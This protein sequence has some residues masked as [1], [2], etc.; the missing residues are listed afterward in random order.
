MS[1]LPMSKFTGNT[2]LQLELEKDGMTQSGATVTAAAAA[3]AAAVRP[4]CVVCVAD[5]CGSETAFR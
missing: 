4:A 2:R 3:A 5:C 1:H